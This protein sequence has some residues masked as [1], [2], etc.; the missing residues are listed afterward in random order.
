MV[1]V[2]RLPLRNFQTVL[3]QPTGHWTGTNPN[4]AA[5]LNSFT[6]PILA[7]G[8]KF[9]GALLEFSA[10]ILPAL[11]AHDLNRVECI[12]P[13]DSRKRHRFTVQIE[14]LAAESPEPLL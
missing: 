11:H 12:A 9:L 6:T 3:L 4:L 1:R 13:V 10:A 14:F 2:V 8:A 5:N 7:A